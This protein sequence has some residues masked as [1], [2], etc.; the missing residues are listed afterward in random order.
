MAIIIL[1]YPLFCFW[2]IWFLA[3]L[4]PISIKWSI[5][6]PFRKVIKTECLPLMC[7]HPVKFM[8]W[9]FGKNYDKFQW[10]MG[11]IFAF[12]LAFSCGAEIY[13]A[14]KFFTAK[15]FPR[16]PSEIYAYG[17]KSKLWINIKN[18]CVFL[19]IESVRLVYS[20]TFSFNSNLVCEL[21][22]IFPFNCIR[23]A[24]LY[25]YA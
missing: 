7:I 6:L 19:L 5:F 20:F 11:W 25:L 8:L 14:I 21:A 24:N 16:G 9:K 1:Y 3:N 17:R 2:C 15:H 13:F 22:L 4:F 23:I 10:S 18:V 12:D